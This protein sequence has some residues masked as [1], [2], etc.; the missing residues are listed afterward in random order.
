MHTV[1]TRRLLDHTLLN[2]LTTEV[3]GGGSVPGKC[4]RKKGKKEEKK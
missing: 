2:N 3:G 1:K 4:G